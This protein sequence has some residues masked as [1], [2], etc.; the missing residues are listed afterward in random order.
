MAMSYTRVAL[1]MDIGIVDA[2]MALVDDFEALQRFYLWEVSVVAKLQ[3]RVSLN[4]AA[5]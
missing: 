4:R 2:W 5:L 1:V 3:K